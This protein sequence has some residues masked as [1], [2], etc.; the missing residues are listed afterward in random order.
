MAGSVFRN[1]AILVA[2]L[3]WGIGHATR[4]VPLI[5]QLLQDNNRVILGVTPLTLKILSAEF[6]H[7]E[8][9]E[10]PSYQIRYS[11]FLPVW[12]KLLF[13][14]P[15]INRVMEEE[16]ALL[17]QLV[18]QKRVEVV[19]SDNRYGLYHKNIHSVVICHQINLQAPLLKNYA[20][21]KNLTYLKCFNEVW[22]PDYEDHN[23]RLAGSLSENVYNLPVLYVGPLSRLQIVSS[24]KEYD[25][26]FLLSGPEPSQT[27]L[28][29]KIKK[30]C[31]DSFNY[32]IALISER[33][34]PDF[35]ENVSVF[36][37]PEANKL[38]QIICNSDRVVCRSGYSTLMDMHVLQKE[39]LILIPTKGQTEQE[40]LARYW[41]EHYHALVLKENELGKLKKIL[42]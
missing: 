18:L 27:L 10:L 37:L 38:A 19:I 16:R 3:D 23:L 5:K 29:R 17:N 2:P 15:R 12:F 13:Q 26:L 30:L 33:K 25:I 11:K 8:R 22:V 36:N 24:K 40:Y 6:P 39:N 7:L 42:S 21:K 34:L 20:A 35:P 9:V 41:K 28:L 14:L 32:K 31:E 1:K 4:C